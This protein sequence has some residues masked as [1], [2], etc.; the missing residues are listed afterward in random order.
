MKQPSQL[1]LRVFVLTKKV[2]NLVTNLI[3]YCIKTLNIA[4]NINTHCVGLVH[5]DNLK[6]SIP[7]M[8]RFKVY[9]K[10]IWIFLVSNPGPDN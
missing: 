8:E 6:S 3:S 9:K 7:N 4:K 10:Q 5:C 2:C 1:S